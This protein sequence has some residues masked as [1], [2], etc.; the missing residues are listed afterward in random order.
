MSNSWTKGYNDGYHT[1]TPGENPCIPLAPGAVPSEAG[2]GAAREQ[3]MYQQGYAAGKQHAEESSGESSPKVRTRRAV[4]T[5]TFGG[6]GSRISRQRRCSRS[7]ATTSFHSCGRLAATT[8][9]THTT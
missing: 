9:P 4:R 8:R 2:S 6:P 3:W 7:S 5:K 1:V